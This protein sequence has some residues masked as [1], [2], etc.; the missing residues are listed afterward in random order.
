MDGLFLANLWLIFK[1]EIEYPRIR[2]NT[3][4][5]H[6]FEFKCEFRNRTQALETLLFGGQRIDQTAIS[7]WLLPAK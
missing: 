1:A 5:I 6:S 4:S 3:Q 7:G 2:L